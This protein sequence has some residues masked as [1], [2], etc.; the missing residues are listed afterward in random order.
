MRFEGRQIQEH[1][2]TRP[3]PTT[4]QRGSDQVADPARREQVL[5][6]KEPVVARQVEPPCHG[7]GFAQKAGAQPPGL[8]RGHRRGE[9]DPDVR[10]HSRAGHLQ[11]RGHAVGPS[12]LQVRKRI[13]QGSVAVKVGGEPVAP[14]VVEQRVQTHLD[15]PRQVPGDHLLRESKVVMVSR[16]NSLT[17][18]ALHDRHPAT[19]SGAVAVPPDRVHVTA[20]PEQV[21]VEG[22]LLPRGRRRRDRPRRGVEHHGR[23]GPGAL[24]LLLLDLERPAKVR[25]VGLKLGDPRAHR[26]Q[27][28]RQAQ[29]SSTTGLMHLAH[30][31]IPAQPSPSSRS[32]PRR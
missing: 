4:L 11:R 18:P 20:S 30:R 7:H 28:A 2:R 19:A 29:L 8:G 31:D 1:R 9:E 17:E 14:V 24:A 25:V 22:D 3:A 12:G 15:V 23:R 5:R 21:R 27:V 32:R 10:A 26:V 13:E 6:R 16:T